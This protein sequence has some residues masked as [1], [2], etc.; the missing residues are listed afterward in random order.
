MI[1]FFDVIF[2]YVL[3]TRCEK[4][5]RRT[6]RSCG[7]VDNCHGCEDMGK[8]VCNRIVVHGFS[9]VGAA[10]IHDSTAVFMENQNTK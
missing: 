4:Q 2:I 10:V 1:V 8:A 3:E 5:I 7:M 6:H 9:H